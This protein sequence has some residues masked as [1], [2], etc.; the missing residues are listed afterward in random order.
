LII[1]S[2]IAIT[3][4][5]LRTDDLKYPD[6]VE[7]EKKNEK[8]LRTIERYKISSSKLVYT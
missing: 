2:K 5:N 7:K 8:E 1:K 3:S 6:R 4:V